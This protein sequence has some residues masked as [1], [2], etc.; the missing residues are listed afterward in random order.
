MLNGVQI[1]QKN[2]RGKILYYRSMHSPLFLLL[3]SS[4]NLILKVQLTLTQYWQQECADERQYEPRQPRNQQTH[5]R[6]D[7]DEYNRMV[8]LELDDARVGAQVPEKDADGDQRHQPEPHLLRFEAPREREEDEEEDEVVGLV[9]EEVVEDAG[10]EPTTVREAGHLEPRRFRQKV[11]QGSH[12]SETH[13]LVRHV[14]HF[15]FLFATSYT[16]TFGRNRENH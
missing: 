7:H 8:L 11:A 13:R 15:F 3:T 5:G 10:R 16:L 14:I 4:G 12:G 1:R 6:D 2:E 9:V